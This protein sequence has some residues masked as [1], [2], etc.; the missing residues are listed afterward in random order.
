M[1]F[2]TKIALASALALGT[3]NAS[4]VLATV[5]GVAINKD[6]VNNV[7]KAQGKEFDK[8]PKERQKE[9]VNKLIERELLAEIAKKAGVEKDSDYKKA[10]ENF[11]KDL[12]IRVWMDKLYKRT[13]ISDSEANDYYQKHKEQFKIPEKIHARHI[14]VKTE[15]EAKKI[16]EQLKG[17][18]G[19]ELKE[20]FVE[21]A[22]KKSTGPS[23][24]NG[25]DLG[26]FPKGQM[27]KP[28][29]DAAFALKKG[30]ITTKPVKTQFGYHVIYVED[31]K[32]SRI[33]DFKDVKQSIITKLR[34]EAFAKKLKEAIDNA[35]KDAKIESAIVDLKDKKD[36][37]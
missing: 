11:K 17:L 21:L 5:N 29:E 31:I 18:K 19:Q 10:L 1:K 25:G 6:Y 22:K 15:D 24:P 37:K 2:I 27:V 20:K 34:Q 33:A 4:D 8:L 7:L 13:L 16:I 36:N 30:T 12:L 3:V 14:L 28:F 9:I 23:G 35:K 26:Y 32:P